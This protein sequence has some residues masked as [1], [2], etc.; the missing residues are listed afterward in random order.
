MRIMKNITTK[1]KSNILR[2]FTFFIFLIIILG[3]I[4]NNGLHP[5]DDKILEIINKFT[6]NDYS[7]PYHVA[8]RYLTWFNM[9]TFFF[10]LNYMLTLLGIIASL[11]TV[12]Y[13][14]A[15]VGNSINR[16]KQNKYIVFLSLLATCFTIANI[17]IDAGTMANMSQHAWR[18]LDSCIIETIHNYELSSNA[19]DIIIT[20]KVIE[21]EKYIETFEH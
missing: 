17:F 7:I 16:E 5:N 1:L 3:L 2:V 18:E 13:A 6:V 19:K 12:F 20:N 11:M 14:S 9:R 21:M 15:N 10:S 8:E 4:Y